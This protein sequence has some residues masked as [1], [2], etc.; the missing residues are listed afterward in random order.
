MELYFKMKNKLLFLA[1]VFLAAIFIYFF[2]Y[3]TDNNKI[4]ETVNPSTQSFSKQAIESGKPPS[5]SDKLVAANNAISSP[6]TTSEP[7]NQSALTPEEIVLWGSWS[8]VR[9][10]SQ[11]SVFFSDYDSLSSDTLRTLANQNDPKAHLVLA[12]KILENQSS[13]KVSREALDE[14]VEHLYAASVLGYTATL[15]QLSDVMENKAFLDAKPNRQF[16]IES[17][18]YAYVGTKRGDPNSE[19]KLN[20]LRQTLPLSKEE[21]DLA[22]KNSITTY[23]D[24][25]NARSDLRLEAFDNE[26]PKEISNIVNKLRNQAT[27]K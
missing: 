18:K 27:T 16:M 6:S 10:Y 7:E 17:Y 13:R 25:V 3:H 23:N 21:N 1:L 12:N 26:V 9:G 4:S 2:F 22:I 11:S 5:G 24:M 14:A 8:E 19:T 15:S 20:I